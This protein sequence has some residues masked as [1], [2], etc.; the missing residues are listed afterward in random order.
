MLID[1]YEPN[2]YA[3]VA[4]DSLLSSLVRKSDSVH[5]FH[6]VWFLTKKNAEF[7]CNTRESRVRFPKSCF[8]GKGK[9]SNNV[10]LKLYQV[11]PHI[12]SSFSFPI[13]T[14]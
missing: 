14:L 8:K 12:G 6:L 13:S 2:E 5:I 7:P 10:N 11:P 3:H 4:V 1:W 9:K